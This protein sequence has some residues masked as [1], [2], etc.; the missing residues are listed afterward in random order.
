VISGGL[1]LGFVGFVFLGYP[2]G[3]LLWKELN[4]WVV[5]IGTFVVRRLGCFIYGD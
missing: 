1:D 2:F 5:F 3:K 4:Y